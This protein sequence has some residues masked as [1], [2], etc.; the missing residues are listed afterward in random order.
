MEAPPSVSD[1][2]ATDIDGSAA[3]AV[4][5]QSIQPSLY[6]MLHWVERIL[7]PASPTCLGDTALTE[8]SNEASLRFRR[9]E[10]R[11]AGALDTNADVIP[12]ACLL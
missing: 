3:G 8:I 7:F 2:S 1:F 11:P 12:E 6:C 9:L 5:A 4:T 10:A